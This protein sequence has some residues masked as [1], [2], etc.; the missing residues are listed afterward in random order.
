MNI[1][2]FILTSIMASVWKHP[3]SQYWTGCF[4][5]ANGKQRKRSTRETNRSKALKIAHSYESAAKAART[6]EQ[7]KRV[8][9]DLHR[10]ITGEGI[11]E[12]ST[13][14]VIERFLES[15]RQEVATSTLVVYRGATTRFLDSLGERAELPVYAVTKDDI[16]F[17][18]N[19][20]VETVSARSANN[21]L[22]CIRMVFRMAREEGLILDDP[23]EFV[24]TARQ[25]RAEDKPTFTI[26]QLKQVLAKADREW[27]SMILFGL[28]TGQRLSDVALMRR[29]NIDL[30]KRTVN[31]RTRKTGRRQ[32][33]PIAGPLLAHIHEN[34]A[35]LAEEKPIHARAFTIFEEKG[36]TAPLSRQ[37]ATIL[38]E[39]GLRETR[40]ELARRKR[41]GKPAKPMLSFH[42]LR[43]TAT[44]WLHEAGVPAAVAQELIGHD[45]EAMHQIYVNVGEKALADAADK[46]PQ[47]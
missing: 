38:E 30:A 3:Q 40:H 44:T 31:L 5:D 9:A 28:Y 43:H 45:S 6:A 25:K 18:R 42:C 19:Q 7:V 35:D 46:L 22:K 36:V 10:E 39:A 47:L 37:F 21:R 12:V 4:T 27:R 24:K 2:R 26:E 20:Q 14:E 1:L 11:E 16:V 8:M 41:E 15:R 23:T 34:L 17:F 32:L 29:T 33:I 13:R